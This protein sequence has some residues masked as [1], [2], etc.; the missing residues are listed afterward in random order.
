MTACLLLTRTSRHK[1]KCK[2]AAAVNVAELRAVYRIKVK[3]SARLLEHV[4][5]AAGQDPP[6]VAWPSFPPQYPRDAHRGKRERLPPLL[7]IA[8][9]NN[10]RPR[11]F[12]REF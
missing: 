1:R 10:E 8:P 5:L 6:G 11:L 2:T 9:A 7:L 4:R 12:A 3:D